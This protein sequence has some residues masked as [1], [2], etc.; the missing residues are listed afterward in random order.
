MKI[1]PSETLAY[2]KERVYQTLS[3]LHPTMKEK[4]ISKIV[5][6]IVKDPQFF[7]KY[8]KFMAMMRQRLKNRI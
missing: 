7:E 6:A 8:N 3:K 4:E 1:K 5:E 2:K